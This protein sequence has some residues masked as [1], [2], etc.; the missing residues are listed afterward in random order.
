MNNV[1]I[2]LSIKNEEERIRFTLNSLVQFPKVLLLDKNSND[3][4]KSIVKTYKNVEYFFLKD[5][6]PNIYSYE[7]KFLVDKVKTDWVMP[8][9]ASDI[10]SN[11]LVEKIKTLF[12]KKLINNYD[13]IEL[14]YKPYFFGLNNKFS[15][16]NQEYRGY[17]FKTENLVINEKSIHKAFYFKSSRIYR[18][19]KMNS[20]ALYHLTHENFDGV[21]NRYNRYLKLEKYDEISLNDQLKYI[22]KQTIKLFILKGNFFRGKAAIALSFSFLSYHMLKYVALW[23]NKYGKGNETYDELREKILKKE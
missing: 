8:L 13:T 23:D 2:V 17:I 19:K 3:K 10:I 20:S 7:V 21:L 4:T 14:P 18:V 22:L 5:N 1:T 9:T 15:P 16:W 11:E 12:S 6:V